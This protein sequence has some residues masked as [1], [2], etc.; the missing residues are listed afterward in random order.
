MID[1]I[2]KNRELAVAVCSVIV[3][4]VGLF[5][6]WMKRN[7]SH[8]IRHETVVSAPSSSAGG[9]PASSRAGA[10]ASGDITPGVSI[11]GDYLCVR[12]D[13]YHRSQVGGVMLRMG[14]NNFVSML[15]VA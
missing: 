11:V 2:Q 15:G 7:T 8:T 1:F 13:S 5:T 9:I 6:A 3:A 14:I 12:N 10:T 4:I